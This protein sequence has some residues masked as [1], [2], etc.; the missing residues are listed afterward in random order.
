MT[1]LQTRDQSA[2]VHGPGRDA[3]AARD[4]VLNALLGFHRLMM[5][6][7]GGASAGEWLRVGRL[8][9]G[10]IKLLFWLTST[11][12]QQMSHLAQALGIGTPAATGLVD[13]LVEH[14]LA[15]REHSPTDRRVVLVRAT[16]EGHA[17]TAR[18]RQINEDELRSMFDRVPDESLPVLGEA[19]AVLTKALS[20]AANE[21]S[22]TSPGQP[23]L[24]CPASDLDQPAAALA[25]AARPRTQDLG[26]RT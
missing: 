19:L 8:S 15:T 17:L 13:K 24:A 10:Q 20:D 9:A 23:P 25:P 3:T 2:E 4:A 6:R 21:R 26:L 16:D 18:L 11:G 1:T 5:A 7:L 22:D 12:E 14:G